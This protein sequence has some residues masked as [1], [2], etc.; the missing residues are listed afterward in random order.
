MYGHA[1]GGLLVISLL[2]RN[3]RLKI[4]GVI[5]TAPMLG[6]PMNRNIGPFKRFFIK[7][8]GHYLEVNKFLNCRI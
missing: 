3:P 4:S 1:M 5:T 6:F 8:F 7:N 2:I